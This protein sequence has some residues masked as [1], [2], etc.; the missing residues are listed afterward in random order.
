MKPLLAKD[1]KPFLARFSNF[2][3]GELRSIE[4]ISPTV[5]K[6]TL[7]GQDSAR[8]FDW[9]SICFEFS[10]IV[11]ARLLENTKLS[12]VDMGDGINI[13]YED[14]NFVFGVGN[15]KNLL[16]IKNSI[17]FLISFTL[18]YEERAF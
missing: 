12:L 13:V 11:D 1:L 6:I 2:T 15:Y 9:L 5:V 3:D 10:G 17:C 14:G 8:G 16:N 7:A 4:I 18:K